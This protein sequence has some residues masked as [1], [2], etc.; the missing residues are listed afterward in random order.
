MKSL[1]MVTYSFF[2]LRNLK[3]LVELDHLQHCWG[4]QLILNNLKLYHTTGGRDPTLVES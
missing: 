2:L 3:S 1:I 4:E